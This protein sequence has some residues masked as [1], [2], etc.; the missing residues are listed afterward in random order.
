[1]AKHTQAIDGV[2]S[3]YFKNPISVNFNYC[4]DGLKYKGVS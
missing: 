2:L 4:Q 3:K 1:M